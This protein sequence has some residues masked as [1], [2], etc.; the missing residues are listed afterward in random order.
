MKTDKL[1]KGAFQ[2][3]GD[4]KGPNILL[5]GGTHGNELAGIYLIK[6][7]LEIFDLDKKNSK[8]KVQG[9]KGNIFF[10]F[11]NLEAI[12]ENKRSISEKDL[13]RCFV[14]KDLENKEKT[15]PEYTRARELAPLF[16]QMDFLFD[17]HATNNPSEPFIC[18]GS[19]TELQRELISYFPADKIMM[20][21]SNPSVLTT[22]LEGQDVL[23]TTDYFVN[24]Y[25]GSD[26]A[27]EKFGQKRG[28]AFAYETGIASNASEELITELF[29]LFFFLCGEIID[30]GVLSKKF[31][32][33]FGIYYKF[34]FKNSRQKIFNL[35]YS[36]LVRETEASFSY[37]EGMEQNWLPVKKGDLIGFYGYD[38]VLAQENGL[39]L[40]PK[41]VSMI[42]N[43]KGSGIF[44]IAKELI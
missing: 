16:G 33:E 3:E 22:S 7:I 34:F 5:L 18:L 31:L 30:E 2:L 29:E 25:G 17:I 41:P 39:L 21:D 9:L 20:D 1:P 37:A 26:W 44:Y 10:A 28:F 43:D 24:S 15:S 38:E 19:L 36:E 12:K 40:F 32:E 14:K 42:G 27:M 8:R 11:G 6:R 13:N 35:A 4:E 23:G